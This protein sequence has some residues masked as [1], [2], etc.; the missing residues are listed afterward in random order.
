[1]DIEKLVSRWKEDETADSPAGAIELTNEELTG[2]NG[3]M[4]TGWLHCTL[5]CGTPLGSCTHRCK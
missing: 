1:M 5:T 4:P 2:V 3:A